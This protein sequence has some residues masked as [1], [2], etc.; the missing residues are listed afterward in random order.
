MRNSKN[1]VIE[2]NHL[3]IPYI[4]PQY[5]DEITDVQ[6][7]PW[8]ANCL[9]LFLPFSFLF[10]LSF[11]FRKNG[12]L[13]KKGHSFAQKLK[14]G[15]SPPF[16]LPLNIKD[17][18]IQ[19]E[20]DFYTL[21][22]SLRRREAH[23]L[24]KLDIKASLIASIK[25]G[26]FPD[27]HFYSRS[28]PV[29]YLVL[30]DA[31]NANDA[32]TRL[33]DR[34]I[35]QLREEDVLLEAF[36]YRDDPRWCFDP[37][38]G[39]SISLTQ[40]AQAFPD[41]RLI[42]FGDGKCLIS[43]FEARIAEWVENDMYVWKNR[44][45]LT[46]KSAFAWGWEE[47]VLYKHFLL[48]PADLA[49][50]IEL[51]TQF[52]Y[53]P[54]SEATPLDKMSFRLHLKQLQQLREDETNPSTY[55][56]NS[57]SG[58]QS[59]LG[60][61]LY[62]WLAA[63]ALFPRPNWEMVILIGSALTKQMP[64]LTVSY[65]SLLR[66]SQIPFLQTGDLS[67][68]L[69]G[70]LLTNL[71]SIDKEGEIELLARTAISIA[72]EETQVPIESYARKEQEV[73][74]M[75]QQAFI[76][77]HDVNLIKKIQ[78]LDANQ[79][80]DT[81]TEKQLP[82]LLQTNHRESPANWRAIFAFLLSFIFLFWG[83]KMADQDR[84]YQ[85]E[86]QYLLSQ[87]GLI[88]T[89]TDSA[90][91]Y[92]NKGIEYLNAAH[93]D[94]SAD[95]F[96]KAIKLDPD[97]FQSSYNNHLSKYLK[98]RSFYLDN[99]WDLASATFPPDT[100]G[101]DHDWSPQHT[102]SLDT[103]VGNS[104][105]ARGLS[106]YYAGDLS[107]ATQYRD[108]VPSITYHNFERKYGKS[109]RILMPPIGGLPR[110]P[111]VKLY[112]KVIT[113]YLNLRSSIRSDIN[114]NIIGTL[115]KDDVFSINDIN[116]ITS[117]NEALYVRKANTLFVPK[118]SVWIRVS[119]ASGTAVKLSEDPRTPLGY[120]N[121][122]TPDGRTGFINRLNLRTNNDWYKINY[123]DQFVW[124]DAAFVELID[125]QEAL[126]LHPSQIA[127]EI[128]M[129]D[130]LLLDT[131]EPIPSLASFRLTTS[132]GMV[133]VPGG[134]FLMGDMEGDDDEKPVHEVTLA[135]FEIG[136]YP[137]T[138]GQW[139]EI[140]GNNPSYFQECKNCPVE[141]VSWNDVQEF[142]SILNTKYPGMNYRLPT[143]AEWEFAAGGGMVER[144]RLGRRGYEYAGSNDPNVVGWYKSN[145]D[146]LDARTGTRPVGTK[147]PNKLMIYDMS[148]NVWE[149]CE[150]HWHDSYQ[151]A[152]NDGSA[153]V[154][155]SSSQR[156][157]RG[158]SWVANPRYLRVVDRL[159]VPLY[160]RSFNIGFR[161]ARSISS[162]P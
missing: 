29:E 116:L 9:L 95:I 105:H 65:S 78:E 49:G 158:G 36:H 85:W 50:Q 22:D 73:Q 15:E 28:K 21:A 47:E 7:T 13:N 33:F 117:L 40:L 75:I 134:S 62:V 109:L 104:T 30:L 48:L 31:L 82:G 23:D 150:D 118:E 55:D 64:D 74:Q 71:Q 67:T 157:I 156:V 143:E 139:E 84:L 119:I 3:P 86:N 90:A 144:D 16:R 83:F 35:K 77:P 88:Q 113:D 128:A 100:L 131:S 87:F 11:P 94:I 152:P 41:H 122:S 24:R 18:F 25:S 19:S 81:W 103:L 44:A 92:N 123:E 147:K 32:R 120:V 39:E 107:L 51:A 34:L 125:K 70:E 133:I 43:S 6:W 146:S 61:K 114:T 137:V 10:L 38:K 5:A 76:Q 151:N 101:K 45:I 37:E 46:P 69:R 102:A 149:W 4:A 99:E 12:G 106:F 72:L 1:L 27:F 60:I 126:A 42:I 111:Q 135:T 112:A 26:G 56:L 153:W 159:S 130:S 17:N 132:A 80:L 155:P 53:G 93:F 138:Q 140:M 162:S 110:L 108:L 129:S 2:N 59:F 154:S 66:L 142:I 8:L 127:S 52:E 54:D 160:D 161:L 14:R 57:I 97:Q 124:V 63:S 20:P 91:W 145:T 148:G 141:N 58:L 115:K 96:Q 79:M 136:R 89:K 68:Q 98:A 121:V